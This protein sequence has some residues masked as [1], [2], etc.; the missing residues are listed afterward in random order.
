VRPG[1]SLARDRSRGQVGGSRRGKRPPPGRARAGDRGLVV[2][3]AIEPVV[4]NRRAAFRGPAGS[5]GPVGERS[6]PDQAGGKTQAR[7]KGGPFRHREGVGE[8]AA[9]KSR[10]WAPSSILA[11]EARLLKARRW[12]ACLTGS[13]ARAQGVSGLPPSRGQ[14]AGIGPE[15]DE[16]RISVRVRSAQIA[17]VPPTP[18]ERVSS[19]LCCPSRS[20]W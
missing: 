19:T 2:E 7:P 16:Q 13:R 18:V 4:E 15:A 3:L 11:H 14:T 10:P 6:T 1:E 8:P 20:A 17:V 9:A 5:H 12:T